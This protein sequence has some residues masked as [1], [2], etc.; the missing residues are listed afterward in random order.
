FGIG[1][2]N[3]WRLVDNFCGLGI[4][5]GKVGISRGKPAYVL[6]IDETL[7]V[8]WH[9]CANVVRGGSGDMWIAYPQVLP[10][11]N[12]ATMRKMAL[13]PTVHTTTVKTG[14]LH[15]LLIDT[16]GRYTW[17]WRTPPRYSGIT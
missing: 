6:C 17:S 5:P 14:F 15:I 16:C 9:R 2:D 7:C 11:G 1:G 4:R 8:D 3:F 10:A 13:I 12:R